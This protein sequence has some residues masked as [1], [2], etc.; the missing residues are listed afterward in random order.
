MS[1]N[2]PPFRSEV[3]GVGP[4]PIAIPPYRPE[5][6]IVRKKLAVIVPNRDHQRMAAVLFVNPLRV[7]TVQGFSSK[8]FSPCKRDAREQDKA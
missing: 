7:K 5:K 8:T 2:I 4:F 6:T 3:S 1:R